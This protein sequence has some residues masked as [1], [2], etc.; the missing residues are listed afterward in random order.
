M[1]KCFLILI[2]ALVAAPEVYADPHRS[3]T[4]K[5]Q[6]SM[7]KSNQLLPAPKPGISNKKAAGLVMEH[8][9]GSRVLGVSLLDDQGPPVYKVRTLS[10]NGVV[11]SVFVDGNSGE[12]FE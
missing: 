10:P 3:M 8:Y 9:A 12:V 6:K 7:A 2:L 5:T 1:M 11:R 4:S